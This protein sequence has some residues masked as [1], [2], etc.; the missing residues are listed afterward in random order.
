LKVEV[1]MNCIR[2]F[3][4]VSAIALC[5]SAQAAIIHV[6]GDYPTIGQAISGSNP[7]DTISLGFGTFA[8][9]LSID[10]PL[11]II[12]GGIYRSFIEP[13]GDGNNITISSSHVIIKNL[14]VRGGD[15]Y[16]DAAIFLNMVDSCLIENCFIWYDYDGVVLW[17]GTGN[18]IRYNYIYSNLGSGIRFAE[19]P[20]NVSGTQYNVIENNAIALNNVA[21]I[22]F[23]HIEMRHYMNRVRGNV[24]EGNNIGILMI[25]SQENDISYNDISANGYRGISISMCLGGGENNSFQHNNIINNGDSIQAFDM[26]GNN[27]WCAMNLGEGNYWSDYTGIDSDSNGIGDEPVAISGGGATDNYPLMNRLYASVEGTVT[28]INSQPVAGVNVLINSNDYNVYTNG[29]GYYRYDRAIASYISLTF[30]HE[31][32][33]DTAVGPVSST[34]G[35]TT[36]INMTMRMNSGI[37]N[38]SEVLP[39]SF[40]LQQNYPNPFNAQTMISF[41]LPNPSPVE[42]AIYDIAGAIVARWSYQSLEAGK[43][44]IIW[45]ADTVASGIYFA[46]L[47]VGEESQTRRMVLLK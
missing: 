22:N 1:A 36:A 43:H 6:P 45:D 3:S 27:I 8:E 41:N 13:P 11:A 24:I 42:L 26:Y 37:E 44:D 25:C 47:K 33:Q 38:E 31:G 9:F 19:N 34:P 17:G 39:V 16:T 30:H 23:E 32:Y 5:L 40:S 14:Q 20:E 10:K 28:D 7:Y 21:G 35:F 4:V 12:G 2:F 46:R 29:Q 18:I 15:D